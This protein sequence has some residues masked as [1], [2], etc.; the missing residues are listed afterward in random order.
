LEDPTEAMSL[1]LVPAAVDCKGVPRLRQPRKS[2]WRV[3]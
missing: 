1:L 2:G 3:S